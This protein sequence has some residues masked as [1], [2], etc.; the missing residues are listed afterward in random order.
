MRRPITG[1]SPTCRGCAAHL[2]DAVSA[3]ARGIS[4]DTSR[5]EE[6]IGRIDPTNPEAM[7]EA[8]AGG[9]FEPEDTPEQK[10]ALGRLETALALVEGWVDEV[11][12]A[13]A[14]PHL[15]SAGSAARD[16]PA[17]AR[18]RR[19]RRGR[20]SPPSSV[21]SCGHAGCARPRRCG[22]PSAAARGIDGRD[23]I[24]AHPD[25]LPT[26]DDLDS[27]ADFASG[28]SSVPLDLSGLDDTA[29]PEEPGAAGGTTDD[30]R[31]RAPR[32]TRVRVL[33][34]VPT[35][36]TTTRTR[37]RASYLAFLHAHPDGMTRR[38][39]ARPPHGER[40]RARRHRRHTCC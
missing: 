10:A 30:K 31:E 7:Q 22:T 3:Y 29:A 4:V 38:L 35:P 24:W 36:T 28:A 12:D 15:P 5:L 20:R 18:Q 13:A 1:C 25:L 11:V 17:P 23:A 34:S 37:L 39:R 40:A 19:A 16:R 6:L 8:L 14:S 2:V 21:S 27:P 33:G 9:L 26:G 32:A